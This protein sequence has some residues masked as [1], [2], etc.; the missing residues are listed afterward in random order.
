M[1]Q[2]TGSFLQPTTEPQR[3]ARG[4]WSEVLLDCRRE[5]GGGGGQ[6]F[7]RRGGGEGSGTQKF[8]CQKWPNQIFPTVNFVVSHDGHFGRGGRVPSPPPSSC[9]VRPF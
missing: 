7:I 5:G 4:M 3:G 2:V 8:V 6:G 9:G 1:G